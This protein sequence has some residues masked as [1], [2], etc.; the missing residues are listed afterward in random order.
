M[1][2]HLGTIVKVAVS[3]GLIAYLFS[4]MDLE[5]VSRLM[6]SADYFYLLLALVSLA[7]AMVSSGLKWYVLMRAQ[8]IQVPFIYVLQYTFVGFFFSNFLPANV[9]GDLMRG[10]GLARYTKQIEEAAVSVIVDRIVGLTGFM[11]S[12]VLAAGLSVF[13]IR[14]ANLHGIELAAAAGLVVVGSGFAV[15]LSRRA[16]QLVGRLFE[17]TLLAPFSGIYEKLS[18]ALDAYRH[19]YGSLLL[20]L[21]ISFLTLTLANLSDFFI[22]E[23]LGG[24]IRLIYIFL[25]NPIISFV[26]MVPISIGGLGMIQA[27]YPFFYGLVGI[28]VSF[29]FAL[30][31]IKQ[32]TIY[33]DSLPGGFFWLSAGG[34]RE[35][36]SGSK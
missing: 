2:K 20:A 17:L 9:G 22:S 15:I 18:R 24:G 34:G 31:L 12:A 35:G 3:L 6:T 29:T 7:G 8:G 33:I 25:F 28:P 16:R 14:D 10:Y 26:L 11:L 36:R 23:A 30:S 4:R 19:S 5:E 21:C 27:A 32:L 1:R 13:M